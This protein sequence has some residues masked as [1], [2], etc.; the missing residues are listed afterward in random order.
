MLLI[1]LSFG[2]AFCPDKWT[3]RY[4]IAGHYRQEDIVT[5]IAVSNF[6]KS[7]HMAEPGYSVLDT[8]YCPPPIKCPEGYYLIK[9]SSGFFDLFNISCPQT[10]KPSIT[11]TMMFD[12]QIN[13]LGGHTHPPRHRKFF[14]RIDKLYTNKLTLIEDLRSEQITHEMN[15]FPPFARSAN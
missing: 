1:S 10:P 9:E 15:R 4:A 6:F 13:S 12:E 2:Q 3:L 11:F 8:F 7:L 14:S 5:N